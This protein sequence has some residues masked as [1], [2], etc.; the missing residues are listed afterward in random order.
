VSQLVELCQKAGCMRPATLLVLVNDPDGT[1]EFRSCREHARAFQE[2]AEDNV[3]R[4][5]GVLDVHLM[6]DWRPPSQR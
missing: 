2:W 6:L 3:A 4:Q 5:N 1:I